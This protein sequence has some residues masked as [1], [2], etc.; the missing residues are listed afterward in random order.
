[1]SAGDEKWP[2]YA[3]LDTGA[4]CSAISKPLIE[5]INAPVKNLKI[6]LGTFDRNV[7]QKREVANFEVWDLN[8]SFKINIE[9]ALVGNLL[10]TEREVPPNIADLKKYDHLKNKVFNDLED[11]SVGLLLDAKHAWTFMTGQ[12]SIGESNEPI[13]IETKFGTALIGPQINS[14]NEEND[15]SDLNV[16]D[17]DMANTSLTEEIRRLFRHDF[18]M[19]E[20]ERYPQE[21]THMSANDEYGLQ[22]MKDS[23]VYDE[24]EKRYQIAL[25]WLLG[26]EETAEIFKNVDFYS[27]ALNRHKKLKIKFTNDEVLR[28]GSFTQMAR[29][30]E[31]GHARVLDNLEVAEGSPVCY[32]PIHVVVKPNRPGKFRVCQD[33]AARVGQHFLNK[34][35]L[36]GPDFLN[37]LVNVMLRFRRK[38]IVL[39]ADIQDFFYQIR[40]DPKDAASLR[41]LWWSDESMKEIITL[42]ALVHIF[43]PTSSPGIS[44]FVLRHHAEKIRSQFPESVY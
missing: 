13:A 2:T 41:F 42:E 35:L 34:Y 30:L 6:N 29:T 36:S 14:K 7:T 27:N 39:T 9:N 23:I 15:T 10:S 44:N 8:E 1:M 21:M 18:I 5:K 25:P 38:E 32:L 40:V 28:A 16:I 43:G 33:A 24:N 11:K 37:R 19:R 22:Q 26:R 12:A 3:L 4:N 20:E 17:A 31:L